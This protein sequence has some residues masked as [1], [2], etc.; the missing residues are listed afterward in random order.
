M[1]LKLIILY[2]NIL[3]ERKG[4]NESKPSPSHRHIHSSVCGSQKSGCCLK[5]CFLVTR[6]PLASEGFASSHRLPVWVCGK[7]KLA[8]P[9]PAV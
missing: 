1:S 4:V 7:K 9:N 3:G 6:E 8:F 5:G 2:V